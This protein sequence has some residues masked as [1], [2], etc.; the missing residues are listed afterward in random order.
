MLFPGFGATTEERIQRPVTPQLLILSPPAVEESQSPLLIQR[1]S[2]TLSGL[3]QV[4]A[5][6]DIWRYEV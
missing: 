6:R 2:G 4:S 1:E 3:F 5:M